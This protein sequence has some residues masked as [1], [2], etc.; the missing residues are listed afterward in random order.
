M[1]LELP[2]DGRVRLSSPFGARMV[3]GVA[4]Y[5]RGIDLIGEDEKIVRAPCDGVIGTSA[6]I[7]KID[8]G[9]DL[10]WQWGNYVRLDTADGLHIFL[11][12][13]DSRAVVAGE[14]VKTGQ[15]L[16]IMGNTGYSFGA[17]THFE[18]RNH[19]GESLDPCLFL[20][21]PNA[22][23]I[24]TNKKSVPASAD[25]QGDTEGDGKEIYG[26]LV[27]YLASLPESGW[28]ENEGWWDKATERGTVDGEN[29]RGFVTR[30]QLTAILGRLGLIT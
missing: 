27:G 10:T 23:G 1:K 3:N 28:S 12:H 9:T 7:P 4:D 6:I 13:L 8:G 18:V 21:I 19:A 24:Y 29:P 22:V 15:I 16:G 11:C 2:F 5:H 25:V 14:R 17:H 26:K 20:G 30:E